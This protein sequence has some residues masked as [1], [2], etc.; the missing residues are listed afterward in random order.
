MH[1]PCTVMIYVTPVSSWKWGLGYWGIIYI[2]WSS[3]LLSVHFYI[4]WQIYSHL[5]TTTVKLLDIFIP[6]KHSLVPVYNKTTPLLSHL[7]LFL[8]VL[9]FSRMLYKWILQYIALCILLL[10]FTLMLFRFI[11]VVTCFNSLF[12]SVVKWYSICLP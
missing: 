11:C 9:F 3:P 6:L 5:N 7:I 4:Y 8:L 2:P 10:S 1:F 12:L